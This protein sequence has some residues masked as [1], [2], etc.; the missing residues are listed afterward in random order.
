[1]EDICGFN[2]TLCI[3]ANNDRDLYYL[4]KYT[5]AFMQSEKSFIEAKLVVSMYS[6]MTAIFIRDIF[7]IEVFKRVITIHH[8]D[9]STDTYAQLSEMEERLLGFGFVKTHRA[10]LVSI[11]H[12]KTLTQT[13]VTL[14]DG[15]TVPVSKTCYPF[16]KEAFIAESI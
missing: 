16:V 7:F 3:D 12:I 11:R 4:E 15:S 1:M 10:Y 8:K 9:G 14:I 2:T 13:C 6:Y 5:Q